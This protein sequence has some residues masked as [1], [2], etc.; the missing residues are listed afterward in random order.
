[1]VISCHDEMSYR[2]YEYKK[3][4]GDKIISSRMAQLKEDMEKDVLREVRGNQFFRCIIGNDLEGLKN[5]LEKNRR[6]NL[7]NNQKVDVNQQ[8]FVNGKTA[9][10]FLCDG[11]VD[12][13]VESESDDT[14]EIL[15]HEGKDCDQIRLEMIK[16]VLQKL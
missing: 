16:G 12:N 14:I 10:H 15:E 13:L 9:L 6:T 11:T 8:I 3:L 4:K 2:F 5:I 1:M 7:M